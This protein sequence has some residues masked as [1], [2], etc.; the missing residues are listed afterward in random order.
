[1]MFFDCKDTKVE[2]N[3]KIYFDISFPQF[4]YPFSIKP[5]SNFYQL[6]INLYVSSG[7]LPVLFGVSPYFPL[8]SS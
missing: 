4:H 3:G 7:I 8:Q 1:M 2:R 5:L 6:S